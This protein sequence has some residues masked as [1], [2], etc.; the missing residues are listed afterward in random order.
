MARRSWNR[1]PHCEGRSQGAANAI[2]DVPKQR[3]AMREDAVKA[4]SVFERLAGFGGVRGNGVNNDEAETTPC[5]GRV[6]L[7]EA[8]APVGG[9]GR[10]RCADEFRMYGRRGD[11]HPHAGRRR[12]TRADL[13][14]GRRGDAARD[15]SRRSARV[16]GDDGR[17]V[18]R[19]LVLASRPAP[20]DSCSHHVRRNCTPIRVSLLRSMAVRSRSS[21][22]WLKRSPAL[23][24]L[25]LLLSVVATRK[26]QRRGSTRSLNRC[27]V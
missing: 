24:A 8:A 18:R 27:R 4:Q 3:V 26:S 11:V 9:L 21:L 12:E 23:R 16:R 1:H 15:E 17:L 13:S 10:N 14:G 7:G 20:P 2:R 5:R 19:N 25:L 6:G 22:F